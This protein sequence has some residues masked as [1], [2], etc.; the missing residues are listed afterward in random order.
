ML[1]AQTPDHHKVKRVGRNTCSYHKR[2]EATVV[3]I[4]LALI[5]LRYVLKRSAIPSQARSERREEPPN[6]DENVEFDLHRTSQ[7]DELRQ[8]S[9]YHFMERSNAWIDFM[10][11]R[12]SSL[13]P[14]L[15]PSFVADIV[16]WR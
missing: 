14:L 1:I 15:P 5:R 3:D 13:P 10:L 12:W 9:S 16:L 2:A 4:G 6:V 8:D 7:P 11:R